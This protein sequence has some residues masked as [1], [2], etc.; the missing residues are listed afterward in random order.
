MAVSQ[1]P[2]LDKE[3]ILDAV[4]TFS[5]QV[6]CAR[7]T[8][9]LEALA[10]RLANLATRALCLN[11]RGNREATMASDLTRAVRY[12]VLAVSAL[13]TLFVTT[14]VAQL[15][16]M[17]SALHPIFGTVVALGLIGGIGW[18]V[19]V[20][21]IAYLRLDPPL[22]PPTAASGPE[23]EAFVRDHLAVL[24]RH[25]RFRDRTLETEGE[26]T[27]ALAEL[28][29]DAEA[30]A[31]RYASRVF[32][33]TAVSQYGSLD[34]IIVALTQLRMVWEI[35]HVFQQ[36][37]SL[38]RMG[39]LYANVLAT[40]LLASRLDRVDLSEYLRPV[41][42]G[43]LGQSVATVPGVAAVSG[44]L[45]N[46]VFQGSVSA[47]LTLRVAMVAIAYSR[48][49]VRPDRNAVWRNAIT[50]A[51]SLVI[52]TVT[53]GSADFTKAFAVAAAKTVASGVTGASHAVVDGVTALGRGVVTGATFAGHGVVA[54]GHTVAAESQKA[55]RSVSR[56][57]KGAADAV[58]SF[59][60]S[61]VGSVRGVADDLSRRFAEPRRS[62][63]R[64]ILPTSTRTGPQR[65]TA[66]PANECRPTACSGSRERSSPGGHVIDAVT[67]QHPRSPLRRTSACRRRE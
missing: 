20:P 32:L 26:L 16:G 23:H 65:T 37:P 52:R 67:L 56:A 50:R 44:H 13:L 30:L 17:A 14:Q 22:V 39:A 8:A 29:R 62:L 19:A 60:A 63:Q 27:A 64:T 33:G 45:S 42:A 36:R 2:P 49:T 38:R 21:L 1:H 54:T 4:D 34:A 43:V 7:R 55:G 35:G 12:V 5:K 53:I 25:P 51:G 41:I 24:R 58:S 10:S 59:G 61:A 66:S 28:E 11:E 6:L 57:A 47:F 15:I 3:A 40:S 31:N 48:A 9:G 18:L 46:A